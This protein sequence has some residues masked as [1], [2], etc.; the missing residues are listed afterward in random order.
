MDDVYLLACGLLWEVDGDLRAGWELIS[1]LQ[2]YDPTQRQLSREML[3]RRPAG[4][5]QLLREALEFGTLPPEDVWQVFHFL[6]QRAEGETGR[7]RSILNYRREC[8]EFAI[9]TATDR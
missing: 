2:S 7:A 9:R 4:V 1:R 8:N 3:S 5:P 6:A